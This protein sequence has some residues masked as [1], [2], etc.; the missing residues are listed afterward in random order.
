MGKRLA[1]AALAVLLLAVVFLLFFTDTRAR[2]A[3]VSPRTAGRITLRIATTTSID[4]SGLLDAL[5]REFESR[6]PEIEVV[7]VAV[8]TGQALEMARRGDVDLVIT[9]DRE[10]EDKFISEG[11]GILGVTF[12]CNEFYIVGPPED[13]AGVSSAGSAAEAF[14]RIYSAGEAGRTRFVSR[15]DKSG[16]HLKELSLWARA[17]L[18][19]EGKPWYI[20]TGQGMAQTLLIAGQ[21]RAYTLCDSSTY[22]ALA[23]RTDL[24]VLY[25]GDPLLKNF[26]RVILVSPEKFPWVSYGAAHEFVKFMVSS[27]GQRVIGEHRRGEAKLFE[28]CFGRPEV[29]E[30][31][32]PYEREQTEYWMRQLSG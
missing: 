1:T 12:A 5:K 17:G 28:A 15:G 27:E 32:G 24:R 29:L 10:L 13:Q 6:H 23:G 11:Y 3:G 14:S 22:A 21:L 30:V 26:Y 9:H 8:G 20:E 16:T 7:W 4:A 19:P 31:G 18:D 2:S 25:R